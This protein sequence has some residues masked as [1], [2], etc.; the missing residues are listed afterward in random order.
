MPIPTDSSQNMLTSMQWIIWFRCYYHALVTSACKK[1]HESC[2]MHHML[3]CLTLKSPSRNPMIKIDPSLPWVEPKVEKKIPFKR[4]SIRSCPNI[5]RSIRRK[6]V[7]LYDSLEYGVSYSRET[8][9]TLPALAT[10][11]T[12]I[13]MLR[14]YDETN[15]I[16]RSTTPKFICKT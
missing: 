11:P 16:I 10:L 13:F 3:A 5:Y 8:I 12:R 1:Q 7:R 6:C 14:N 4:R 9:T 2:I 15:I